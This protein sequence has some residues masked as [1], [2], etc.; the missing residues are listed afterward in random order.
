MTRFR[1]A[2]C[3]AALASLFAG[4]ALAQTSVAPAENVEQA[5]M[6]ADQS[7]FAAKGLPLG[8]F[9]LFPTLDFEVAH[10][11]N[12]YR[13][14]LGALS[15]NFFIISPAL[16]LRSDWDRHFL[17]FKAS[18]DQYEYVRLDHETHTN[19][20]VGADGRIDLLR[21]LTLDTSA[22]YDVLHLP[23][24]DPNMPMQALSPTRYTDFHA[25]SDVAQYVGPFGLRVGGTF[26]RLNYSNTPLIGGGTFNNTFQNRNQ[27]TVF[28]KG[29][30]EFSPGY[31]FFTQVTYDGR[32]YQVV[33]DP[34]G[35]DRDSHGV[36][37]DT[38]LDVEVSNLIEG[39]VFAGYLK[40]EYKA[41]LSSPSGIDYGAA[42]TWYPTGL[43]TVHLRVQ[44][45]I[46]ETIVAN[47][48]AT[49]EQTASLG[50]DYAFRHD[51]V[52]QAGGVFSNDNFGG[53]G[54]I[55]K[56]FSAT[57]G[58]KYLVNEYASLR[59]S[60]IYANRSST[61]TGFGYRDNTVMITL[62]L[63]L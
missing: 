50:A 47:A 40:Q 35:F 14:S 49:N 30:Y 15:D 23:R 46:D 27:Y 13:T 7:R 43:L 52:L 12:V 6:S 62:G 10:D 19:Y 39:N 32:V 55:D 8:D 2:C 53:S 1:T 57:V 41:P 59:T 21:G 45:L 33:P 42:L 20:D 24:G 26:D 4:A 48:S 58:A 34:F 18:L 31:A 36:R 54:R 29:N 9:R 56:V 51:V 3:V 61:F 44:H 16:V 63:Q 37:V 38:G 28:A 17:A 5:V 25:A 11:D 60:Y 22:S